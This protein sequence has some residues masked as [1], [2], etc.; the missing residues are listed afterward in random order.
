MVT[1]NTNQKIKG[2]LWVY[3]QRDGYVREDEKNARKKADEN[4]QIHITNDQELT[5]HPDEEG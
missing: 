4:D 2:R 3:D 1:E 5:T